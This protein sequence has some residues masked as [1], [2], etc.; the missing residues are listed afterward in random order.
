[1]VHVLAVLQTNATGGIL[2]RLGG[3]LEFL[4]WHVERGINLGCGL[5]AVGFVIFPVLLLAV[6]SAIID[7]FALATTHR[8]SLVAIGFNANNH[9]LIGHGIRREFLLLIGFGALLHSNGQKVINGQ[10]QQADHK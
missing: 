4:G 5:L 6:A 10:A 2:G 7:H 9:R 1:M 8:W 3:F